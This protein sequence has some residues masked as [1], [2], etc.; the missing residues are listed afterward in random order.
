MWFGEALDPRDLDR[1]D[2]F[3][4]EGSKHK[5]VFLAAGTSGVVYPAAGLVDV[6]RRRGGATW[7]VNFEAPENHHR[8]AHFVRGRSGEVLPGLFQW[9]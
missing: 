3:M 7:L 2:S 1:I 9:R 4:R 5:L 8:F 6:A